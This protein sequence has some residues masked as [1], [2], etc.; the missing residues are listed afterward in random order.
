MTAAVKTGA[1]A[2]AAVPAEEPA[3]RSALSDLDAEVREYLEE[4]LDDAQAACL[5][6]GHSWPKLKPG[7]KPPRGFSAV[8]DRR[9]PGCFAV[10][11]TCADCGTQ[12]TSVTLP[13][14]VFD[15]DVRRGYVYSRRWRKRPAG[16]GLTKRDF[17][18][19]IYRRMAP[20]L[21][22]DLS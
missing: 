6:Y 10:T 18:A 20:V 17:T 12:R 14:G 21:F 9:Q 4:E 8:P 7:R 13:G 3:R 2:L 1:R 22:G 11:E 19:E 16:S 5:A 15:R